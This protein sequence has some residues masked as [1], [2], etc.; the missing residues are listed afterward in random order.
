MF[1]PYEYTI[2]V[3]K[4]DLDG[5]KCFI[6]KVKEVPDIG[7]VAE[8]PEEA[9]AMAVDAIGI[10]HSMAKEMGH[11]FPLPSQEDSICSGRVT[12]RLPK[13]LHQKAVSLAE[14]EQ[15]SLNLFLVA[16]IAEKV[17]EKMGVASHEMFKISALSQGHLTSAQADYFR[18][19]EPFQYTQ[20][21]STQK[22]KPVK[23]SN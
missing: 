12:L 10:L 16:A 13:K 4:I 7:P 9:Y 21:M 1:D 14:A 18:R 15:V 11:G 19:G 8:T 5:D 2:Q 23:R 20:S 22:K 3:K 17:G 6:A